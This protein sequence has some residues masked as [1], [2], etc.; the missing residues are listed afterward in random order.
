MFFGMTAVPPNK[1]RL[2][3]FLLGIAIDPGGNIDAEP[4]SLKLDF[5]TVA[6]PSH[7]EAELP[8]EIQERLAAHEFPWEW[9]WLWRPH[10]S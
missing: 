5:D 1:R 6:A 4:T 8:P 2:D 3:C 9:L 10:R 7:N